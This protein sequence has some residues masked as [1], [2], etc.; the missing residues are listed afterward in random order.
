MKDWNDAYKAG[1]DIRALAD[2]TPMFKPNGSAKTA[3]NARSLELILRCAKDIKPEQIEW[4]WEG[5]LA[6]GKHTAIAGEPGLGKSQAGIDI[7]A[8]ITRGK[9]WPNGEGTASKGRVV[10][11]SAEDDAADTIVPRLI[12][13]ELTL[14][15]WKFCRP[16]ARTTFIARSACK[17][18]FACWRR[19]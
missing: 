3:E 15:R 12:P 7:A 9:A 17:P 19:N 13:L 5:R 10:I 14:T 4:L 16:F 6:R 2:G 11:L 1:V 18:I 8:T